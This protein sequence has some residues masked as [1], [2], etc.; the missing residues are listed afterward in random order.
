[1]QHYS[2]DII[3]GFIFGTIVSVVLSSAMKLEQPFL[4][5]RFKSKEDTAQ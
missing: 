2:T 1:M 4:M 5:S 3:G